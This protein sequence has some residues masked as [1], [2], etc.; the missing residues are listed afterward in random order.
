MHLAVRP[1]TTICYGHFSP[2]LSNHDIAQAHTD[3]ITTASIGYIRELLLLLLLSLLLRYKA[4]CWLNLLMLLLLLLL[5]LLLNA[6]ILTD[7]M[8][9]DGNAYRWQVPFG[10]T[11]TT[12]CF[13]TATSGN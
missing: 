10:M 9:F 3:A 8:D 11:P 7:K 4:S 2:E 5:L 13:F 6:Y 1:Q 12:G